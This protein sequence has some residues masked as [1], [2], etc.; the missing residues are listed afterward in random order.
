LLVPVS[1]VSGDQLDVLVEVR[2]K[3]SVRRYEGL[4]PLDVTPEVAFRIIRQS[5]CRPTR[6]ASLS[7]TSTGMSSLNHLDC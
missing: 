4:E 6:L 3:R 7:T 1:A 2:R 5:I